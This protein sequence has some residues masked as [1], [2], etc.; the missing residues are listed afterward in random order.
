MEIAF[1]G[2]GNDKCKPPRYDASWLHSSQDASDIVLLTGPG[3]WNDDHV[4]GL[5]GH[6]TNGYKPAASGSYDWSGRSQTQ[7]TGHDTTCFGCTGVFG[8][9]ALCQKERPGQCQAQTQRTIMGEG[10]PQGG[11]TATATHCCQD[12]LQ[13]TQE[14]NS[15]GT[16]EP[17]VRTHSR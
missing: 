8:Q 4:H 14:I 13:C 2:R 12:T 17:V 5:A 6:N 16:G 7:G 11:R 15:E 10:C 9:Y 1:V 3:Y